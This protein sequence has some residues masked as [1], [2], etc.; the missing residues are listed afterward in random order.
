MLKHELGLEPEPEEDPEGVEATCSGVNPLL[1]S[2]VYSAAVRLSRERSG[3]TMNANIVTVGAG[4][5]FL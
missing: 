1:A 3:R 2:Q 5:R 4:R